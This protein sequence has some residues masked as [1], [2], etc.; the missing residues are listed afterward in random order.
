MLIELGDDKWVSITHHGHVDTAQGYDI[1]V[2]YTPK[3][4]LSPISINPLD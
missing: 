1:D 3:F 2:L 4:Y